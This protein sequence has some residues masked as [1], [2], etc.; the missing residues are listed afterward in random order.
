MSHFQ[1][2]YQFS[3]DEIKRIWRWIESD[4]APATKGL[5]VFEF[6]HPLLPLS[7]EIE[8]HCILLMERNEK[9][10]APGCQ[11]LACMTVIPKTHRW[12]ESWNMKL[13][14]IKS[15]DLSFSAN[16]SSTS[17]D[18]PEQGWDPPKPC[19]NQG[20]IGVS[21]DQHG[22]TNYFRD[23]KNFISFFFHCWIKT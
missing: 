8:E 11:C 1:A 19:F 4:K 16:E 2:L 22:R 18:H 15:A 5:V 23:R 12:Q 21:G 14:A 20:V 6:R 13:D 17:D 7:V 10:A 3:S 9:V